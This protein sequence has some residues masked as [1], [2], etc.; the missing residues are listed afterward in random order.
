MIV[1][2]FVGVIVFMGG[3]ASGIRQASRGVPS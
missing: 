3:L 1:A 2:A